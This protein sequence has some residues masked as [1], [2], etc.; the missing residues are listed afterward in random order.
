MSS[1]QVDY[2]GF[3][4]THGMAQAEAT[5][6]QHAPVIVTFHAVLERKIDV[7]LA[8]LLPRPDKLKKG[9]DFAMRS[10]SWRPHGREIQMRRPTASRATAV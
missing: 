9:F 2:G 6:D 4:G 3:A 5:V 10:T 8:A 1:G 7:V